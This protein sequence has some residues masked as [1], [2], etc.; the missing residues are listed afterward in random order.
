MIRAVLDTNVV[1]SALVRP[2]SRPDLV[3]RLAFG[4]HIRCFTSEALLAEYEDVLGRPK[5]TLSLA[6]VKTTLRRIRNIFIAVAPAKRV[7][8]ASDLDDNTVLECALEARADYIVTGNLRHFPT[9]FQDI[10]VVSPKAFL[11]IFDSEL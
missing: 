1:V 4:E 2:N 5:P 9:Q 7:V 3:L 11:T 6:S 10:R 8:A